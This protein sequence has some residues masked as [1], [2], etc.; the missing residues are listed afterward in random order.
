MKHFYE[1]IHGWVDEHLLKIYSDAVKY[2]PNNSHFVEIGS[3]K[4]KSSSYMAVEI[5]NSQKNIRFDCVDTWEGSEEHQE[6][7]LFEDSDVINK[8]LFDTFVNNMK[9]VEKYYTPIQKT[10]F[11]ASKLYENNS[12]DFIFID[13]AHDYDNVSLDIQSWLPKLKNK[14][15]LAGHDILWESVR[16]AVHS[17][18]PSNEIITIGTCWLYFKK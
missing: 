14:R 11:E 16:K 1:N 18:L 17:N 10:S 7:K 4:G 8:S 3:W 2:L 13:G 12:L 15:Y 9:S 6:G 5:A